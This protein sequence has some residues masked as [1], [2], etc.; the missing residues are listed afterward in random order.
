M[1]LT[2]F[3]GNNPKPLE[4]NNIG[5][6]G[7]IKKIESSD[8]KLSKALIKLKK[9]GTNEDYQN[10]KRLCYSFSVG[11]WSHRKAD[12]N[13]V[14]E[15]YFMFDIDKLTH[16]KVKEYMTILK[17]FDYVNFIAPSVSF[18]GLRVG[19]KTTNGTFENHKTN[20]T[21]VAH[22][23]ESDA[24]VVLDMSCKSVERHFFYAYLPKEFIYYNEKSKP[25]ELPI[26][27]NTN[28]FN[29][30]DDADFG[31]I[32]YILINSKFEE[33]NRSKFCYRWF[34]K[35]CE[36]G[37]EQ[38]S[39]ESYFIKKYG[40]FEDGKVLR[41]AK[42]AYKNAD[43]NSYKAK[44]Q[45]KNV[46]VVS[47]A[48][49]H[50]EE[51]ENVN[52]AKPHENVNEVNATLTQDG[53][54]EDVIL[55]NPHDNEFVPIRFAVGTSAYASQVN[56]LLQTYYF[57]RNE[58]TYNVE[59]KKV[60]NR[61]DYF[62]VVKETNLISDLLEAGHKGVGENVSTFLA[63]DRFFKL[64][65]PFEHYFLNLPAW[66]GI[67]RVKELCS[68]YIITDNDG[69]D[70]ETHLKKAMCRSIAQIFG[71]ID[72]NKNCITLQGKSNDGKTSFIRWLNPFGKKHHTDNFEVSKKEDDHNRR[73]GSCFF[74]NID[75]IT[76]YTGE[77]MKKLKA[78][79]TYDSVI[80]RFVFDKQDSYI[81]R[82]ATF[83]AT[84]EENDFLDSSFGNVRFVVF[85]IKN[86]VHDR[87]GK[88]GYT[89]NID[90]NQL[91]AQIYNLYKSN[92][93]QYYVLSD[94]EVEESEKNN[95]KFMPE[96]SDIE[97][98]KKH[99]VLGESEMTSTDIKFFLE[100]RYKEFRYN[101]SVVSVGRAMTKL[102]YKKSGAGNG[103]YKLF[104]IVINPE[105]AEVTFE[106]IEKV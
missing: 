21:F 51:I 57:R 85:K 32:D 103:F 41:T 76:G 31:K 28:I 59:Y 18:C 77:N 13:V 50:D 12:A 70:F 2:Y 14:Y 106:P 8:K 72:F 38:Q 89:Q 35:A 101:T 65:N 22:I 64:Y 55:P 93:A 33:G 9:D 30:N 60:A 24:A 94:D 96:S 47:A 1:Y 52:L 92:D 39:A 27:V 26:P 43:F 23:L 16:E 102:G 62:E 6:K 78:K 20:Y 84:T 73:L 97:L 17:E 79:M 61:D 44:P 68:K 82:K 48:L 99:F 104:E 63:S 100:K 81:R 66:D 87:G 36:N 45:Q 56:W 3:L 46:N 40:D 25:I 71:K 5:I 90:K 10:Q 54:N 86:I 19:I 91:W 34:C 75:E 58:I 42:D 7:L 98:L 83:W 53:D 80:V 37:L 105:T 74:I 15:N 11:K 69:L 95:Q 29:S 88:N 4:A 49:T 67:D